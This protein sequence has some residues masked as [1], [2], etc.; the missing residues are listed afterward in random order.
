MKDKF[1]KQLWISFGIIFGSIIAAAAGLY[2][3]SGSL[4]TSVAKIVRTRTLLAT[5]AA[6][7]GSLAELK[8]DAPVAQQYQNA[9]NQLLPDQYGLIGFNSW[10]SGIASNHSVSA[11][12]S[13][14]GN[15][16][17]PSAGT[18]G[19]AAFSMTVTGPISNVT[20]FIQ[21]IETQEPAYLLSLSSFDLTD[22]GTTATFTGQGNLYFQS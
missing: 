11:T 17:I 6:A 22:D 9:I 20:A 13:F 2:V 18:P 8:K 5:Q 12:V 19:T 10:I 16:V 3:L 21:D 1:T 4:D 15:P 14:Q 7:V